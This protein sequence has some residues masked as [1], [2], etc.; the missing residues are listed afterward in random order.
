MIRVKKEYKATPDEE[1]D[2]S[3]RFDV[4][5]TTVKEYEEGNS[6]DVTNT[7]SSDR[8]KM[9]DA[10]DGEVT[11]MARYADKSDFYSK[12]VSTDSDGDTFKIACHVSKKL[13]SKEVRSETYNDVLEVVCDI[14]AAGSATV[15]GEAVSSTASGTSVIYF[16]K[17]KGLISNI[18]EI[19]NKVKIGSIEKQ[20]CEKTIEEITTIN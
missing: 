15:G 8:I 12:A 18:T 9:V 14:E 13:D 16:A 2:Y 7:I 4:N 3:T 17:D 19:C 5:G 11:T 6:L 20:S 1:S 10:D